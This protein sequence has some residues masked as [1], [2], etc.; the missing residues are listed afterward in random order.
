MMSWQGGGSD[1]D[2]GV[3]GVGSAEGPKPRG[4]SAGL[5]CVRCGRYSAKW[6]GAGSV[7]VLTPALTGDINQSVVPHLA[8]R[9]SMV[10]WTDRRY[11]VRL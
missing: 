6:R 8:P 1:P 5:F 7:V 3:P 4:C 10:G 2:C 9:P 11:S